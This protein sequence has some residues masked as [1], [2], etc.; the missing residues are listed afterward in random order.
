MRYKNLYEVRFQIKRGSWI[1]KLIHVEAYN[2]KEAKDI[3]K[4]Y[5]YGA[6]K[7]H[8]FSIDVR[9]VPEYAAIDLKH[10][11]VDA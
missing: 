8:M 4:E 7:P 3:A 6:Y 10:W 5:W 9:R 11:F 1:K 2:M